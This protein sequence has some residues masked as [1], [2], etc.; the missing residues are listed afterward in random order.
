MKCDF[1]YLNVKKKLLKTLL[2]AHFYRWNTLFE[3]NFNNSL[4]ERS[5]LIN[6]YLYILIELLMAK[7]KI[8]I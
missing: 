6:D 2:S 3:G 7:G 5:G 4:K 8:C 1:D